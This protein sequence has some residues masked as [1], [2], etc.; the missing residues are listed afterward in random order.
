[1]SRIGGVAQMSRV[2]D[3]LLEVL[4]LE[5][6]EEGIFRGQS[7]DLGWGAVY[8]GQ[9]L[10]QGLSAAAQ[11]VDPARPAH[12]FHGYFLRRGDPRRPIVYHVE[13]TRDG[14]SF[15]TRRV[16]AVQHGRRWF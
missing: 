13:S 8:G 1:M 3:E 11:T 15:S 9:A 16:K 14:A 2:L 10:G 5:T 12:S 7:Q 4:E 6:I